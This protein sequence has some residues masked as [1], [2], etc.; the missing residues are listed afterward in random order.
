MF[1]YGVVGICLRN[2]RSRGAGEAIQRVITEGLRLCPE[3]NL[4]ALKGSPAHRN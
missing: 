4:L 1:A 3:S 2:T